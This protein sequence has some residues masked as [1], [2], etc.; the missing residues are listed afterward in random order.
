[1]TIESCSNVSNP[2]DDASDAF[3]ERRNVKTTVE[4]TNV[5]PNSEHNNISF[6]CSRSITDVQEHQVKRVAISNEESFTPPP[7]QDNTTL[8]SVPSVP[9]SASEKV[10]I[11]QGINSPT[12]VRAA[13]PTQFT[14]TPSMVTH[15]MVTFSRSRSYA[16]SLLAS[17]FDVVDPTN[18]YN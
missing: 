8:S 1:M 6:P 16:S 11:V 15:G 7:N 14:Q 18:I 4:N 9:S 10:V 13:P 17:T 5:D 2:F 3:V 12:A